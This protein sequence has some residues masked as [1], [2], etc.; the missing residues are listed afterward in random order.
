MASYHPVLIETSP[1]HHLCNQKHRYHLIN[2]DKD[3]TV[4]S[5]LHRGDN[6]HSRHTDHNLLCNHIEMA[7][8]KG[9]HKLPVRQEHIRQR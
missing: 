8:P 6:N 7:L 4:Q 3:E 9:H 2:I 1:P 5:I